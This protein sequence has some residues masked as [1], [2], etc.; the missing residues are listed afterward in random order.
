MFDVDEAG[1]LLKDIG[2]NSHGSFSID[3][4]LDISKLDVEEDV[5][6]T[7]VFAYTLSRFTGNEKVL[8]AL[9]QNDSSSLPLLVDC[10][11]S[12]ILSFIDSVRESIGYCEK[13]IVDASPEI[14]FNCQLEEMDSFDFNANIAKKDNCNHSLTIIHSQNYSKDTIER[15]ANS[16][17][18]IARGFFN[19]NELKDIIYTS[20]SDLDIL[21]SYNQTQHQSKYG[22][23]LDAFN[24]HLAESPDNVLVSYGDVSYTYSQGAFLADKIAN[25]LAELGVKIQD[26]VSFLVECSELYMLS[27]LGIVSMGGVYVPLDEAH[28]DD[29][30]QFMVKDTESHVVIV[31]D[32]TY[33]RAR[34]L[35]ADLT[36][37]NISDIVKEEIGTLPSLNNTCGELACMLYTSG[38]TGLPKGVKI[39]RKSIL[40]ISQ[41]YEDTYGMSKDDVYGL[42]ASIGF[43]VASFGIF[44]AI[45]VGACLSVVP[46]DI[47]L[48]MVE[49]NRYYL[50]QNITHTVMTTQ[51]AKLFIQNVDE[52]SL[53]YLLTGG[54]KLGDFKSP[55]DFVLVDVYGPTESFMFTNSVI[56]KD[57]IDFSSVGFLNN[58]VK[59]YILDD[60]GRRVPFGAV[61]ELYLAGYQVAEGYL[62][63]DEENAK[64]F[65]ENPFDDDENYKVLYRTGDIMRYLPDGSLGV[66]GRRDSQVKIRGNRVELLE[67]DE[68]IREIDYVEDVTVQTVK[69]NTNNELVAYVVVNNDMDELELNNVISKYV[70]E[71]KPEYMIPSFV[72]KLDAIP[73]NVNGKVDKRALPAVDRDKFRAEYVAPRTEAE[74]TV[75][76]IF[77]KI[78]D[79]ENVGI[80]DDFV[81][82][83]GDSLTAIRF[84]SYL[85]S[86]NFSA[87]NILK[88]RTPEAIAKFIERDDEFDLDVYSIKEGC[89]L[90]EPQLNV[91][92]DVIANNKFDSYHIPFRR[93]IDKE[94]GVDRICQA[95]NTMLDVH[96]I[97]G[98]CIDDS[99]EVPY[100]V[101]GSKPEISIDHNADDERI[102]NFFTK[103]FDLYDSLSRFLIVETDDECQLFGVFHH[104]IFDALSNEVFKQDLE[105]ILNGDWVDVDDSFLKVSAFTQQIQN[106][107]EYE[108]A[109]KFYGSMLADSDDAGVLLKSVS[110]DG[111]GMMEFDLDLNL[112]L[113]KSFL[114]KTTV[115]ESVVFT[116]VFAYTLSRFIGDDKVLF[117]ITDNGRDRFNN[118]GAIGMFVNT[119]PILV[120]CKNHDIS[121]FMNYMSGLIYDVMRYDYYPFRLLA[122]EYDIDSSIIFQFL[123]D[124]VSVDED[125]EKIYF[126]D[127]ELLR[128][129]DSIN[130]LTANVVQN[131][132]E[133]NLIL[134][135]S[136]KY[137][138]DLMR[139]FGEVYKLILSQLI[140]VS[141]LSDIEFISKFD[142][143]LLDSINRNSHHWD[144]DDIL[145][146]FNDHLGRNQDNALVSFNDASYSYAECA[147]I[148]DKIANHLMDLGVGPQDNVAFMVERSEMYMFAVLGIL[149]S[150][151]AFVP[152]DDALP[153]ER[154]EFI[155]NDSDAKVVLVS[156]ETYERASKLTDKASFL[157]I[158]DFKEDLGRLSSLP[159]VYGDTAC[160]LYTSGTTGFPKGVKV[161]RK[162]ILNVAAVYS[163]KF[164]FGS[165]DVYGLFAN[166]G[167][168]AG[169]WAICQTLYAGA[170]LSIVPD[171]IRL[172]V[173]EL[174]RY[175]L[176]HDVNHCMMTTQVGKLFMENID[177]ASLDVLMVG[178]EKLGDFESPED[179][180]LIDGFGP[181]ETFA[182]ISSINNSDKI[183]SSSIG[184]INYN[185]KV[186]ILDDEF[187]R[188]PV[189]AVGELYISGYQVADG[190]LNREEDNVKSFIDN[191]FDDDEDY[192][193]LYRTGDMVRLLPDKTLAILNRRD[194]QV[195]IRGNR[196]ELS[197]IEMVV[198]EIGFVEDVTIQTISNGANKELVAYVV[199]TNE[200]DGNDLH[201]S[202]CDYVGQQKP[203]YMV[204][205]FVVKL[206]EIPLNVNGKVDKRALPEVN[207]S[208]LRAEYLAPSTKDE[209]LIVNAF[210][211]VFGQKRISLNDD[212]VRLGGDS[213]TAIK[214]VS[215]LEGYNI[216]VA[217]ILNLRTPLAIAGSIRE[218]SF[219]V[220]KYSLETGCPLTESQLN[221]YLDILANNK[222]DSYLIPLN[223]TIP[224][225]YGV[226]S[227]VDSIEKMFIV[228]PILNM[229]ITEEF[230]SP[231]LVKGNKPSIMVKSEVSDEFGREF[232]TKPF[233][234]EDSLCRFLILKNDE[235]YNL[236]AVFHHLIFDGLSS[237]VFEHDLFNVLNHKFIELDDMFLK[238]PAFNEQI[239]ELDEFKLAG[240]FY[241]SLLADADDMG[242]LLA[243][244]N[245]DGPGSHKIDLDVGIGEFLEENDV[246]ENVLFTSVFAYTLSRFVGNDK[247][248][249]NIIDNGRDRLNNFNSIGMY[250]NTLPLVVDC[251]NRDINSFLEY[252]SELVYGVMGY[253]YYP[254]RLMASKYEINSDILFQFQP[255]WFVKDDVTF[256]ENT[257]DRIVNENIIDEMDDL[258]CE[259]SV[260]VIQKADNY[261]LNI[262]YS[263]KYSKD[264]IA[265]FADS[266][267]LILSDMINVNKLSEIDCTASSD[268]MLLDDCNNTNHL[269]AFDD[270]M[271]A[272]NDNLSR[273]PEN[274][275]VS[276]NEKSYSYAQGAF[277]A[278]EIA[279]RLLD[280]GVKPQDNVA[281][282][283][284][285]SEHYM[286]SVLGILSVGAVYVPLDDE[287]PDDR[288][289]FIL[290]DTASKLIIA[291]DETYGRAKALF[292]GDVLNISEIVGGDIGSLGSL[293]VVNGD[294]ACILYTSGSTG[295]PKGVK[296]TRKSVLNISQYYK[297]TYGLDSE[298]VFGLYSS[299][300]FDAS[301]FAIFATVYAGACLSVVPASIR[302]NMS[303][304]NSYYIEQGIKHTFMTT[305]VAKLFINHID[306]TSLEILL[307]G[308]EKLGEFAG[309]DE[310]TL[311]DV[312]GPT[313]SYTFTNTVVVNEKIDYS[314]V[315]FLS[316]N[317]KAYVLD[318]EGRRVPFGAV[319][320]LYISG[321]QVAEG[322]LNR[323]EEN[324]NAF[325]ENPFDDNDDFHLL[326]RTGDLVRFLPDNSLGIVGR[327]DSQ[328]KIRGNRVELPE[329]EEVI[330]EIDYVNDV[331]VQTVK[332]GENN[333]VVAYVVVNE[334]FDDDE[335]KDAV[336][337][338]VAER[339]PEYMIP[340]FVMKLDCIPLNINSKVD[341]RALPEVDVDNLRVEYVAPTTQT[342]KI[343][344]EAFEELFNFE[345]IGIHDDFVNLGGDSLKA[346]RLMSILTKKSVNIDVSSI[347]TVRTPYNIAQ[348]VDNEPEGYGFVLSKRGNADK[349]M[350]LLP[351]IGGLSLIFS[352]LIDNI[353]FE[354]N[355][356]TIDD[357]KYSLH[358]D[359]LNDMDNGNCT[360][361]AY[362]NA[363]KDIFNDGDIIVGYSLGCIFAS[364]LAEKL[365]NDNKTVE[366]CIFIDSDLLFDRNQ[367][368]SPDDV[369]NEFVSDGDKHSDDFVDKFEEVV[370]INSKLNFESPEVK[371][372]I[373]FLSTSDLFEKRLADISSDYEYV[374]IDST[375]QRIIGEDIDKI[376]KY[377]NS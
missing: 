132:N 19:V 228:H 70:G 67:V 78:F 257:F 361:D 248:F 334:V 376:I 191:P 85:E 234:L 211:K 301:S 102:D 97:L 114:S 326:Y 173:Y 300:G 197:E 219:D 7:S 13:N 179:Y 203:E 76:G 274:K 120:D 226:E 119:L 32:E 271:D 266:Y 36:L 316:Y 307:T 105:S 348:H 144:H 245:P 98:M 318:A 8:F 276:Y 149:S 154:I 46:S 142:I 26:C 61:G 188:V 177:D 292:S 346:I 134:L 193:T 25:K 81:R 91:Y 354:G 310:F 28:P 258:I 23:I 104:L 50:N 140:N 255:E 288:I 302:L 263:D 213:L 206:D 306:E 9:A 135:Y 278:Y 309:P 224:R 34:N 11:N 329:I 325:I 99:K 340:S 327:Q 113:F 82:L 265:R 186:Y 322:Y 371:T 52:I 37:L 312:Y 349:N 65:V 44:A 21:D 60:E 281:F 242:I 123:P 317:V 6:F 4:K 210:E 336:C 341:R 39:T 152:L 192:G 332:N 29:R 216:S 168:D 12:D 22:D 256:S 218:F 202:I 16:F 217:D 141:E 308:G 368:I 136:D 347:L 125:D 335:L 3:L 233:D 166:I 15:F 214:L 77:K 18:S 171:E 116:A 237:S 101:K 253:N 84:L 291:S 43:D 2:N 305:Q 157:N 83:G 298:D 176:N 145:D 357:I 287:H 110:S 201:D 195:K 30:I 339:K 366:K 280:L 285:R 330:R 156:D 261:M 235:T 94:L 153:D 92:L 343:I 164:N 108:S 79:Q 204:P 51:V 175:F 100:L 360:L 373:I 127:E 352:K 162:S 222:T 296:I 303:E 264:L 351:P 297:D 35:F 363:I 230:D 122:S 181:T 377:F 124:W 209:K 273:C 372:K 48:N 223:I 66:V 1:I 208:S 198:R 282:L 241:E 33:E 72:I 356:Y 62:N 350:F 294:L 374:V 189:G 289:K 41:Y 109:G 364:L 345:K 58:N 293:P 159:V 200:L 53:K 185:S 247:V 118:Y 89:P 283:T 254:F 272:F 314:S 160:I 375:H 290:E 54:E 231:Y 358:L 129:A 117:N 73:L 20:K 244:V 277:I 38:T 205:S 45:Y 86:F 362:Y 365:E 158:S 315:G 269:L 107:Q 333:E 151:A 251:K 311:I 367:E 220:D 80:H 183:D 359:Q 227:L 259:L 40:N 299:I 49:L 328:V 320:E 139:R 163:S 103:P 250:V 71:R 137:S 225:E 148:A 155:L 199:V 42:Y 75:V 90:N 88:L 331:T 212:F 143:E 184:Q 240:S 174:N 239:S 249:F 74:K 275:L 319:G 221:I 161:T 178:G 270:I 262:V 59:S 369:F 232:V 321:Y 295:I 31:S 93:N 252:M 267:K 17:K 57:K 169:S 150:G 236:F 130:D 138:E 170:C 370:R 238:V 69:H 215:Y 324:A 24:Y 112:D 64:A 27:V 286:F 115:N 284:E 196:V 172:D 338:Y 96:P 121:D 279:K 5:F 194:S 246:S 63:R 47:R 55:E 190:Y 126:D 165:D 355:I 187:R 95:L 147:F 313:E 182:F 128:A 243:S 342:E 133:Y 131:G 10:K 207:M 106:S 353:D 268:I 111:E 146:A 304:L 260:E 337:D 87:A 167:F 180:L 14:I 229:R 56:V 344:V 323:E 68:V